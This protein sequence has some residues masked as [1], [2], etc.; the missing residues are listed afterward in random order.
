MRVFGLCSVCI[1]SAVAGAI[2]LL[3]TS[4]SLSANLGLI[5]DSTHEEWAGELLSL[6]TSDGSALHEYTAHTSAI[7]NPGAMLAISFVPRFACNPIVSITVPK[8]VIQ[9][10]GA[11]VQISF[12]ID[13]EEMKFEA[14]GDEIDEHVKFTFQS[15]TAASKDLRRRLDI[16]SRFAMALESLSADSASSVSAERSLADTN[17]DVPQTDFIQPINFSLLGSRKSAFVAEQACK[18]HEPLPYPVKQ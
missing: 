10:Y 15:D 3:S 13:D 12:L 4:S 14:L 18:T 8:P 7:D 5:P 16:G 9:S 2:I 17:S 11:G 1:Q 6:A